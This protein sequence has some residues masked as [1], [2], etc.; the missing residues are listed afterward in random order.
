M[1]TTEEK[2]TGFAEQQWGVKTLT[3][4]LMKLTE[5]V[6]EVAGAI[7]KEAEGRANW[8]DLDDEIGDCLIVLSQMAAKR[9]RTLED[10]RERRFE[11]IQARARPKVLSCAACDR[12]DFQIGHADGC[13]NASTQG[14]NISDSP[15]E[16]KI[17]LAGRD[18]YGVEGWDAFSRWA[19][20]NNTVWNAT[21]RLAWRSHLDRVNTFMLLA[22]EMLRHNTRLT[23]HIIT[24]QMSGEEINRAITSI[25][26][27]GKLVL[28]IAKK[29]G[30]SKS[31]TPGI[32]FEKHH[33]DGRV[34]QWSLEHGYNFGEGIW[35][36]PQE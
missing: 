1:N 21:L 28:D 26:S 5:E 31:E 24:R 3:Q 27:S 34:Q 19:S 4:V 20:A 15:P 23:D 32:D 6:G 22:G 10:L 8:D 25:P 2:I 14:L 35:P 16:L 36:Q 17:V 13:Q 18:V 33:E 11:K 12:G 9:G 7:T 29:A 30:W